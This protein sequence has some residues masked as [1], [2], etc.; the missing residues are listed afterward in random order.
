MNASRRRTSSWI[1]AIVAA[2]IALGCLGRSPAVSL[3]TMNSVADR[4]AAAASDGLAIG[5]GPVS[6]PRY[7][8]RPEWVTR[9][10]GSTSRLEVDDYRLWAGG[11][12]SNVLAALA[13]N[14]AAALGTQRVVVYPA[15][16][17]FPLDFRVSLDFERFEGIGD[18]ELVLSARWIVRAGAGADSWSGQSEI[19]KPLGGGGSDALVAAHDAALGALA[20]AIAAQIAGLAAGASGV[21]D[22]SGV[23]DASGVGDASDAGDESDAENRTAH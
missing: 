14:L 1:A 15:Q 20:D 10:A 3:Y 4:S 13:P 21:G 2:G 19:R 18:D 17:P 11:F 6:V 23:V 12:S 8:D 9:S 16:A 7:L 5:L 22:A